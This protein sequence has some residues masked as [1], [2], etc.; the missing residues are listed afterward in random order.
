M[1]AMQQRNVLGGDLVPWYFRRAK[2][3]PLVGKRTWG[4]LVG[5]GGDPRLMDGGFVTAPNFA[6]WTPEGE[7]EVEN[8]GVPPD[9]SSDAG[10]GG[11]TRSSRT[12]GTR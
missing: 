1:E 5:I 12:C 3:G 10:G 8:R 9:E 2:L 11:C 4:G 7:W 6:F